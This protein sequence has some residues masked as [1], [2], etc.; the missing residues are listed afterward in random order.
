MIELD[1][2]VD[3]S[4]LPRFFALLEKGI[5][6]DTATGCTLRQFLSQ[7]VGLSDDYIDQRIQTL[8][9]DARPVDDVDTT[10]VRDGATLALSAAMPGLLGASMRKG[11]RYAAMRHG[12]TQRSD[13]R[14]ACETTGR[15]TLKLFNMVA[16]EIGTR[17]LETGV[18]VA[19]A[20]LGQV[21]NR[22]LTDP[23]DFIRSA[24]MDDHPVTPDEAFFT[25]LAAQRVW[26]SI[27]IDA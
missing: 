8:F 17:L 15:V 13:R 24:R 27:S 26:L 6:L 12:I 20:A 22:G 16:K 4:G 25:S 2:H 19:G 21:I 1:L 3:A 14:N 7:Q 5:I 9:L 10:M 11:G 18:E 23:C